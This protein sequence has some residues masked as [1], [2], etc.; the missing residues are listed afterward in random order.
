MIAFVIIVTVT[1]SILGFVQGYYGGVEILEVPLEICT[2]LVLCALA[3]IV[4]EWW[5][6]G[7]GILGAQCTWF[8]TTARGHGLIA[9]NRGTWYKSSRYPDDDYGEVSDGVPQGEHE[10]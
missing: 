10:D 9:R 6:L 4:G 8:A 1:V 2:I 3:A 7:A 5:Y